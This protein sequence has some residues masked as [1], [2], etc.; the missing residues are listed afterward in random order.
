MRWWDAIRQAAGQ[1]LD[2]AGEAAGKLKE[3]FRTRRT[4]ALICVTVCAAL[5]CLCVAA[6]I[7]SVRQDTGTEGEQDLGEA[8]SPLAVPPVEFFLPGEP[9]FLPETLP[10]RERRESWAAE[11]AR[12][13]WIDPLGEG[14]SEY[15]DLMSAVVDDLM[16]RIP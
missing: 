12:P 15:T 11:D 14:A 13:F 6:V 1:G 4:F 8:F 5:L 3:F 10:E 7:V 16:E 2:A 9:D